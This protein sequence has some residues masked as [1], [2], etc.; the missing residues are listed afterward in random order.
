LSDGKQ[1]VVHDIAWGRDVGDL[2]EHVSVNCSPLAAD[3]EFH[4]FFL[5]EVVSVSDTATGDLLFEQ[6]PSPGER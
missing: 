1:I 3:R 5:S 4:F 2:W 6:R